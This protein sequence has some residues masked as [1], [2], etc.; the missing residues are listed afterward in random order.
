MWAKSTILLQLL[1]KLA[2]LNEKLVTLNALQQIDRA[3][4]QL[5]AAARRLENTR[6]LGQRQS[7]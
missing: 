6:E 1:E 5:R 7:R 4:R 2:V 3:H